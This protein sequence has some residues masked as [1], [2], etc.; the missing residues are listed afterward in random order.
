M[1][2]EVSYT[3][4][5]EDTDASGV[6]YYASYF[7]L[8]ERGRSEYVKAHGRSVS[9]WASDGVHVMVHSVEASFR[10]PAK[11]MDTLDVITS[12]T[13]VSPYRGR[14]VQRIDKGVERVVDATVD[15]VCVD[16]GQQ[17]QEFPVEFAALED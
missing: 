14:F 2:H 11:L 1:A 7:R 12:F 9:Q 17:L 6:V 10:K 4:Y 5:Y 13:L 3:V 15:V 16:R 8:L